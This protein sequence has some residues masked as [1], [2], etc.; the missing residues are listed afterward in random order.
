MTIWRIV[1]KN[2]TLFSPHTIIKKQVKKDNNI[3]Y[4]GQAMKAHMGE[5]AR[6]TQ[7]Y[8]IFSQQPK[9]S[10]DKL[11]KKLD[12]AVEADLYYDKPAIHPGTHKVYWKGPDKRKNT[13]DDIHLVDFSKPERKHRTVIID[14]IRYVHLN[15]TAKDKRKALRDKQYQFRW[16]K[17]REDL[18]RIKTYRR[19]WRR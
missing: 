16:K 10:A 18:N 15:E 13:E 19:F 2:I 3:I 5:F 6:P 17:D 8:D 9:R 4:G 14:G 12:K 1:K 7:D 11:Q